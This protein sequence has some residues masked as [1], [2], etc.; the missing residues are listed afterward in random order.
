[1]RVGDKIAPLHHP[2]FKPA[3]LPD[4]LAVARKEGLM[5][6]I[7]E[8]IADGRVLELVEQMLQAG[9]ME[10]AKGWQP[11]DKGTP[12]GAVVS[13]LLSNIYLDGLDWKM[14]RNGIEMVRYADDFILLCRSQQAAQEA[15]EQVQRWVEENGLQLHPSKTRLVN[16]SLAGG[17]DF[18]GYHFERGMKWPRKK[19]MDK[20]KETIR[21]KTRRTEGRSMR[22][23]CEDLSRT[24]RGWFGYFKHGKANVFANIDAYVRGR[25]RS[26]LRKRNKKKGRGRGSDHQRWPNAYFHTLGLYSLKQAHAV[27]CRSS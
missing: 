21:Q 23:V 10:S 22:T 19:S 3:N 25:L 9:V 18:L 27:V 8:K 26:I 20:L 6:H 11:T 5:G 12:Q 17:F 15:M 24:L 7:K 4:F 2:I 16:A 1:M 14:A 13:P